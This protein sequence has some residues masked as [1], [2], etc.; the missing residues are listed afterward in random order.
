MKPRMVG[1]SKVRPSLERI[2]EINRLYWEENFT[3]NRVKDFLRV[4]MPVIQKHLC[5]TREE[6]FK[7]LKRV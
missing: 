7:K 5:A 4:S 2:L 6:Y 3:E 1:S